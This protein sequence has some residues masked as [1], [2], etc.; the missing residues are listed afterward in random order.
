MHFG[1]RFLRYPDLFPARAS[2]EPCGEEELL[3]KFPGCTVHVQGLSDRQAPELAEHFGA[4]STFPQQGENQ[5]IPLTVLRASPT[6]F[7][8]GPLT[9]FELDY[10]Y[11]ESHINIAAYHLMAR[12]DW[13]P[14][15]RTTLWTPEDDERLVN[16]FENLMRT[17]VAYRLI[18]CG[19]ALVHSAAVGQD[20]YGI[21][22]VGQSGAGKTTT[23]TLLGQEGAK[24]LSDDLNIV[25]AGESGLELHSTPFTSIKEQ[26]LA[27]PRSHPLTHIVFLQ[28]GPKKIL[29]PITPADA[30]A[31]L[32][33]C[34]PWVN[35]DH[36][37]QDEVFDTLTSICSDV[38]VFRMT[39]PKQEGLWAWLQSSLQKA[40]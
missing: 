22:F 17:L 25:V 23:W 30:T 16:G 9:T 29:E 36:R 15:L 37:R 5:G 32:L 10:E 40:H 33:T 19:G 18:S 12:F 14:T 24:V 11:A 21:L 13:T 28:Q 38:P 39:F 26:R 2:G 20:E 31:N 34:T 8:P 27:K 6:D 35:Q 7:L 4:V 3:L 1:E